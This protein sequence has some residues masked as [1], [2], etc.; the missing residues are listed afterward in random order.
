MRRP[1]TLVLLGTAVHFCA[2]S[3]TAAAEPP[4]CCPAVLEGGWD[5]KINMSWF[6]ILVCMWSGTVLKCSMLTHLLSYH[7][8]SWTRIGAVSDIDVAFGSPRMYPSTF[9]YPLLLILDV[10][11]QDGPVCFKLFAYS[12]IS[13]AAVD[14]TD[15]RIGWSILTIDK[16]GWLI[17]ID[18]K[19]VS[20]GQVWGHVTVQAWMVRV[21][22]S[23]WVCA[24]V[25]VIPLALFQV[26]FRV[27][28]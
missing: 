22:M 28:V 19:S 9:L 18:W 14:N 11:I 8:L 21:C 24:C 16:K 27:L 2:G 5:C 26:E 13:K 20:L 25:C 10:F 4:D 23:R 3:S 12:V 6:W 1:W 7:C 15:K 17:N